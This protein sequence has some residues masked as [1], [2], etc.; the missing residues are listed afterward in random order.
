[1]LIVENFFGLKGQERSKRK[2][3]DKNKPRLAGLKN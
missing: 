3:K 1:V 2:K